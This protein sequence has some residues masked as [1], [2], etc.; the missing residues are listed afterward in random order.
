MGSGAA[1]TLTDDDAAAIMTEVPGVQVTAPY[2]R[3]TGSSSP[4]A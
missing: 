3:G 2:M 4:A 1:S